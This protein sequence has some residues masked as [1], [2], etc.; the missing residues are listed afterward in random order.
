MAT[1]QE[2][3]APDIVMATM[4]E[5]TDQ[6]DANTSP[7][8]GSAATPVAS[9]GTNATPTTSETPTSSA[10]NQPT[11]VDTSRLKS[12]VWG[13]MTKKCIDGKYK[14]VCNYCG[15]KL[16]ANSNS[17]T[18]HLKFH[19]ESCL[20][21]KQQTFP[22]A[23]Q[24]MLVT[25]KLEG[26]TTIANYTFDQEA[27][28]RTLVEMV[29]LHE[30]PLSIVD[31][32]GFKAFVNTLQ[33]LFNCPTRNT[34]RSDVLK[35]Y[36][37]QMKKTMALLESNQGRVAITTDMWTADNQ[38]KSY[39]AVTAHFVDDSWNLQQRLLRSE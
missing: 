20:R 21:K 16:A 36:K 32:V 15:D 26:K 39:M 33:P 30:H 5:P 22:V 29:V 37:E 23:F 28:R 24:K 6:E 14:A 18:R 13:H 25:K 34:V 38:K 27:C 1:P 9:V 10:P 17:G 19:I 35:L 11:V 8:E 7:R 4:Q 2:Q 12:D 31:Q 3:E